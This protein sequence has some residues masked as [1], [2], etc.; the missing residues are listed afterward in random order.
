MNEEPIIN[1]ID[2]SEYFVNH[3]DNSGELY[4]VEYKGSPLELQNDIKRLQE[5]NEKLKA[6][7]RKYE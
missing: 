3:Y 6:R 1:G 2:V 7:L 4:A 5:E